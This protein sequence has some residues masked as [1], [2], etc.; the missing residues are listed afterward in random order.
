MKIWFLT[1]GNNLMYKKFNT[2]NGKKRLK[3]MNRIKLNE[4]NHGA[5]KN[6]WWNI[7]I[8]VT[9]ILN[10]MSDLILK[11]CVVSSLCKYTCI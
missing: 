10:K 1:N 3:F 9:F 8:I 7:H 11:C 2:Y 4:F 5:F 6:I